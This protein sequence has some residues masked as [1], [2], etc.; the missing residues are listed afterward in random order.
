MTFLVRFTIRTFLFHLPLFLNVARSH[1]LLS[2]GDDYVTF[3]IDVFKFYGTKS[4]IF[5]YAES[6]KG[7]TKKTISRVFFFSFSFLL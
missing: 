1:E 6:I 4:T 7:G 3:I 2:I 5:L